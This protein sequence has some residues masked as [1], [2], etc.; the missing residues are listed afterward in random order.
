MI[1]SKFYMIHQHRCVGTIVVKVM[2]IMIVDLQTV[3]IY[4]LF[5]LKLYNIPVYSKCIF[6]VAMYFLWWLC[7][8][9][10]LLVCGTTVPVIVYS[11]CC[12]FLPRIC[13]HY[14]PG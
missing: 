5:L 3:I 13:S 1:F 12:F 14:Y 8:S 10:M 2:C 7:A 11:R 9:G 6:G 4:I